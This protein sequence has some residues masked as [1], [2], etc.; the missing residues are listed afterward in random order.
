MF[1]LF[2]IFRS[3]LPLHNPIGFGAADFIGFALALMLVCFALA[4]K[5]WTGAFHRFAAQTAWSMFGLFLL[6]I[7]LRLALIPVHPI[8]SAAVTDDFSYL[9]LAD[10][11]SHFRLANPPHPLHQFFETYYVL[12]EPTYS[13]IYALG[14]G[15]AIAI[16]Q[17]I[18]RIPWAGIALSVGLLSALVYWMLR[19]WTSASWSLLGGLFAAIEFGPLSHWMNSYWGGAVSAIAGCLVFGALP[20]LRDHAHLRDGALLGLGLGIQLLSRPYESIFLVLG[21]TIFLLPSIR[22]L[23]TPIAIAILATLPAV[24]LMLA[25]NK[26]VTGSWTTMPYA[27]SR[28]QYGIP[29]TFTFQP[30]P[31]PHRD[32]TAQQ[33]L[34]YEIQSSVHGATTDTIKTYLHRLFARIRFYRFFFLAPLYLAIPFFLP[35]LRQSRFRWVALT[36]IIFMLGTNLYPYFY[37]HYIAALTCVFVL[38]TVASLDQLSRVTIRGHAVGSPAAAL[39]VFL[40]LA[41]FTFWYALHLAGKQDFS[42]ALWRYES[43][44]VIN[45]GDPDGRIAINRQLRDTNGD[46]LVFVRYAPQ[47]TI[48]E[49]IFDA[50]GIDRSRIVWAR[51]LGEVENE[52]LLRYYPRRTAWLLQPDARPLELVPY[53][54]PDA[55][56]PLE[57]PRAEPTGQPTKPAG[58][59]QLKFEEVR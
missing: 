37:A 41:H 25:Q 39:I 53:S 10:T 15:I 1:Y 3:F 24:S 35:L 49:W 45:Y 12:Q 51:D 34:A 33:H 8:P 7:A 57:P 30:N 54:K 14:Q 22:E 18:F 40:G 11:L 6:P 28:Y 50:A 2:H 43:W 46:Q 29:T 52:K 55:A 26:S 42:S 27:L 36:C 20:R 23:R 16:G 44:D 47:H 17:V 21:A 56:P 48:T 4:R 13:S 58:R 31:N 38:I 5:F 32:L 59:P 9:L 19:A